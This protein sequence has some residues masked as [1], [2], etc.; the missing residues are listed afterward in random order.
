[1]S[2]K[3]GTKNKKCLLKSGKVMATTIEISP[4]NGLSVPVKWSL[5]DQVMGIDS[6]SDEHL[7]PTHWA[8]SAHC[9]GYFGAL[10]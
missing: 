9:A 5:R 4:L 2:R 8:L 6:P 1:M 10:Y 7:L 3:T